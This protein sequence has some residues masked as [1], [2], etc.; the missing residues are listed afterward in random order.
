MCYS[1]QKRPSTAK[2]PSFD[3]NPETVYRGLGDPKSS[4]EPYT[5]CYS[6]RKRPE[7]AKTTSFDVALETV[8]GVT[9]SE[10]HPW[11]PKQ[12]AISHENGQK[13]RK[14][15]FSRRP[16]T[17]NRGS[18]VPKIVSETMIFTSPPKPCT[19]GHGPRKSSPEPK[20]VCYRPRKRQK[21]RK[22]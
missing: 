15:R 1:P 5:V 14:R 20:T 7:N 6:P 18:R 4:P 22:R 2:T 11:N 17:M 16:E 13:T 9:G 8:Y 10:N 19:G 3:V 12:C 21:T